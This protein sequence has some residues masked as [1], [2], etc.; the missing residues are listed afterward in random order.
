[1]TR[2]RRSVSISGY[3]ISAQERADGAPRRALDAALATGKLV[4]E[5]WRTRK[6]GSLFWA[7]ETIEPVIDDG[8][9]LLGFAKITRDITRAKADQDRLV[10]LAAKLDAALTNMHQG[11]VLVDADGRISLVNARYRAMYR[12]ADDVPLEG[13]TIADF[14]RLALESRAGGAVDEDRVAIGQEWMRACLGQPGG[15]G[16]I[17]ITYDED[18]VM[19]ISYRALPQGG[20]V[21]TVEDVSERHRSEARIAHMAMHD[22]L[23]GLPNRSHFNARLDRAIAAAR[24]EPQTRVAVVAIDLDGFKEINDTHGHATGDIVLRAVGERLAAITE[25]GQV[26]GRLGGDEF[27]VACSFADDAALGDA[28]ARLTRLFEAPIAADGLEIVARASLGVA[29]FPDDGQ[30]REQMVGNA[31]LAMYRA[32]NDPRGPSASTNPPWTRRRRR[33]ARWP[34][35][36]AQAIERGELSLAYQVQT[37]VRPAHL[38]GY[39]ALLRWIIPCTA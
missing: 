7:S 26:A 14:M 38:I 9:R 33:A 17:T 5:G 16:S 1:M 6:D 4:A 27:A 24:A 2:P 32:K 8:G 35:T 12:I 31:D 25:G 20:V 22:D 10:A 29:L 21:T 13:L 34:P 23:T 39:E 18:S 30:D 3:S 36:F 28:V 15:G 37:S 11:L 19:D